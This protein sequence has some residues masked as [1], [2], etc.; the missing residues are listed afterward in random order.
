M[1][2]SVQIELADVW[3]EHVLA[4]VKW[5]AL[6]AALPTDVAASVCVSLDLYV[7]GTVRHEY[8]DGAIR[9]NGCAYADRM[10]GEAGESQSQQCS[11][12]SCHEGIVSAFVQGVLHKACRIARES[13][14]GGCRLTL[15]PV[16]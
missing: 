10:S 16:V 7:G 2:S 4:S 13:E 12:C 15:H 11:A 5:N 1:G 6:E 9:C 3:R 8:V 14:A